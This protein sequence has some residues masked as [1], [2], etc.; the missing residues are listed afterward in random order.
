LADSG[1]GRLVVVD[2]AAGRVET[3][4]AVPG[5]A[6]GLAIHESLAFVGLSR[7][8]STSDMTGLPIT[9]H[10]ER[11]KCGLAV[12]DLN[13][14]RLLAE[15]EIA[16][17]VDEI[18]DVQLLPGV[19]SPFLSGPQLGRERGEPFWTVPTSR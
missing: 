7:I 4:A 6:R 15:L 16:S 8:R 17:P 13:S 3:V 19:R 18:F 11:L 12:V 10:P 2:P 9:A 5:F 1:T 14:G